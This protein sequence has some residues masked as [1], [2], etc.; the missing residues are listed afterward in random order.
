LSDRRGS[1]RTLGVVRQCAVFER[2]GRRCVW[3][4]RRL[5][6]PRG[7][8]RGDGLAATIDHYDGDGRNHAPDNLLP[9]CARCNNARKWPETF[10]IYLGGHRQTEAQAQARATEQLAAPLDYAAGRALARRW[11]PGRLAQVLGCQRRHRARL[12]GK[13]PP[14]V[15]FP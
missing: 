5:R 13:I 6:A 11:H 14:A 10:A 2:G 4:C 3:C 7:E 8:R 15:S 1:S 12:A 9:S